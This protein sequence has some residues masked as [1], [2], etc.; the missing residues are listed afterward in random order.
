MNDVERL[1]RRLYTE[2]QAAITD[3]MRLGERR[4]KSFIYPTKKWE[5]LKALSVQPFEELTPEQK[6]ALLKKAEN[7]LRLELLNYG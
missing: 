5:G 7:F 2:R 4:E 6:A 1:A 3:F